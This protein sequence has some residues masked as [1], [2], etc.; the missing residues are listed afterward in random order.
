MTLTENDFKRVQC[1]NCNRLVCKAA[2]GSK[3]E[4]VCKRCYTLV[5]EEIPYSEAYQERLIKRI[6]KK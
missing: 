6:V 4:V 1:P 2:P 3:V 5:K